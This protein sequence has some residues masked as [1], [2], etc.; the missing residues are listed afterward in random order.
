MKYKR[1]SLFMV[2]I[3]FVLSININAS[4]AENLIHADSNAEI[5]KETE[6]VIQE[7]FDNRAVLLNK[8]SCEEN[9]ANIVKY[10]EL[11]NEIDLKLK[12]LGVSILTEE[13]VAAQFPET[14]NSKELALVGQTQV[15]APQVTQPSSNLNT[16]FSYRSSYTTGGIK[17]SLQKLIA[18]PKSPSSPLCDSGTR[19]LEN[20]KSWTAGAGRVLTTLAQSAIG[21]IPGASGFLT[22]Y[23]AA[24]AY[25]SGMTT[26][27]EVKAPKITYTWSG[28]TTA[29]FIY[30]KLSGQSDD[31]QWLSL[32]S[33]KCTTS[34]AY[35]IPSFARK[36]GSQWLDP[37]VLT[38]TR[39]INSTPDG[40]ENSAVAVAAY[41]SSSSAVHRAVS[42]IQISGP[43]NSTVQKIYPCYP[44]LPAHCE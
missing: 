12:N 42:Y 36:S 17:Y 13:E 19:I 43:E 4:A 39:E 20:T 2:T 14:K 34:V 6:E 7:L 28:T 11:I 38:G 9:K 5:V 41:N 33:T 40:Y 35:N 3:L 18:Q 44:S 23:D 32:V 1:I 31:Y 16:W 29:S 22:F 8:I 27:T 26:T 10:E 30:V 37:I 15:V 21:E 24:K 25:V